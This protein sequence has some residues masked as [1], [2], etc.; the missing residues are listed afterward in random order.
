ME[1]IPREHK[2]VQFNILRVCLIVPDKYY[3]FVNTF[4]YDKEKVTLDQY[5]IIEQNPTR[6]VYNWLQYFA[7]GDLERELGKDGFSIQGL[8]SDV[9]GTPYDQTSSEFA[10][11][12][13][14]V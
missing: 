9:A 5:T 13:D 1:K 7:P 14:R 11:V 8:Y 4:K 6:V 2:T 10:V 12:A 3:C